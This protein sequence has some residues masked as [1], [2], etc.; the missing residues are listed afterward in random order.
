M[1]RSDQMSQSGSS[2]IPL[3]RHE[4]ASSLS[5]NWLGEI[6][7]A[8]PISSVLISCIAVCITLA[9]IAF[10]IEG[11]VTRKANVVGVLVPSE[12]S[13]GVN[14]PTSGILI[15]SL[16]T[17]GQYVAAGERLFEISTERQGATGELTALIAQQ[18][19]SRMHSLQSEQRL[20]AEQFR[21]KKSALTHR[22]QNLAAEAD[23]LEQEISL[24][25]RRR[26]LAQQTLHK[27]ETLEASGFV[28]QVQTQQKQE[29]VI[30]LNSRIASLGRTRVQIA[31]NKQQVEAEIV[32]QSND[33][34]MELGQLKR[35]DAQ[36]QQEIAEN[37]NRKSVWITAPKNGT[38][39][40]VTYQSGQAV[41]AGQSLAT[42]VPVESNNKGTDPATLEVHLFASSRQAGFVA[43]GQEVML[44]YQAFP[45]QKFGLKKGTVVDV[46][47]TPFAPSELPQNLASTILSN[48]QIGAQRGNSGEALFRIKVR[49][50][51]QIIRAFGQNYPLKPGMALEA[52]VQLDNR[53][54][55]E[56]ITEPLMAL[57]P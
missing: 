21:E 34:A 23:Q 18:L 55:W 11:S 48:I 52:D 14:A 49:P 25:Q 22:L 40:A 57:N 32:T 12:G 36:L 20:R 30:E 43:I 37:A 31:A 13:L 39:T 42:V 45:Y 47:R 41:N 7:L 56:W 19:A 26:N 4:V 8:Q 16:A 53:K 28:S 5:Q 35:A 51:S 3:F 38:V 9:F 10:I 6:R 46:S 1:C 44:R 54:I 50:D 27:F 17:E 24:A 2:S 29:E 15:S 33:L